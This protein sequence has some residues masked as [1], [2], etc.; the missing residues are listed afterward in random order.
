MTA[1]MLIGAAASGSGKTTVTIGLLRALSRRGFAVQP[2]KCG[3]D[4]IDTLFHGIASGNRSVNLDTWLASENHVRFVYRHYSVSADVCVTEGVMG[5]FDGYDR[6]KGSSAH[7]AMLLDLPVIIIINARSTA[8]TMAALLHGLCT[9]RQDLRIAGV[10]F[11]QVGSDRHAKL[12]EQACRDVG[13]ELLGCLPRCPEIQVPSRHLG[14]TVGA[15][16]EID[17]LA[18]RIADLVERHVRIERLLQLCRT[19][20]P[21]VSTDCSTDPVRPMSQTGLRIA[22]ASDSAFN[23]TYRVNIDRLAAS[24]TVITFSPLAGDHLP[25]A[26][27][28]YLPGGYPELFA[29]TLSANTWLADQLRRYASSGGRIMAE[30]GGMIYLSRSLTDA[31]GTKFPMSGVLPL[32]CTMNQARLHLGYRRMEWGN[33]VFHG[34]EFHYSSITN[35]GQLLSA[36]EQTDAEGIV[37]DTCLFRH[38][39]VVAGYTHWYWGE[40]DLFRLWQ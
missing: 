36:A 38:L 37:T 14:L 22:V 13:V 15:E 3:P 20:S 1:H 39:N 4:Y 29:E 31:T 12:L 33:T 5:L 9:F 26:D 24:G 40:T 10:I 32:D 35:H 28:V 6:M 34:H 23:F 8:Y 21:T 2:F 16:S 30:C 17:L 7:I 11:N 18:D 19:T 27:L 25:Q